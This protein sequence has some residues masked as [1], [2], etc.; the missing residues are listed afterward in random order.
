MPGES[1]AFY[2]LCRPTVADV[3]VA[4]G[5]MHK[6]DAAAVWAQLLTTAGMS[7]DETDEAALDRLL[8]AMSERD[9]LSRVAARG[10][11]VRMSSYDSLAAVHRQLAAAGSHA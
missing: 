6:K 2:G 7:G 3:L 4:V 11:R 9:P 1:P 5:R 10:V 8:D